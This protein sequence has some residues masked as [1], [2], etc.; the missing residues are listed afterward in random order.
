MPLGSGLLYLSHHLHLLLDLLKPAVYFFEAVGC[1]VA[2]LFV[3]G[4]FV[5]GGGIVVIIIVVVVVVVSIA[6]PI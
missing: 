1:F 5:V 4:F 3:V 6:Y 2:V